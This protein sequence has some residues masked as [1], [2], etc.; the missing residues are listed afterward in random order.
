[1]LLGD[2]F[3]SLRTRGS[4]L[5]SFVASPTRGPKGLRAPV[6][7]T[8]IAGGSEEFGKLQESLILDASVDLLLPAKQIDLVK[9][10]VSACPA[11]HIQIE[12]F[13]AEVQDGSG[14]TATSD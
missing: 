7:F 11:N 5:G 3:A 13:N 2:T 9:A 8:S 12:A 6:V 10:F 14:I 4:F 1:M